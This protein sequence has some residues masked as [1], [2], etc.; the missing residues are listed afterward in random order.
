[1]SSA[2]VVGRTITAAPGG[3]I[4]VIVTRDFSQVQPVTVPVR[5][6]PGERTPPPVYVDLQSADLQSFGGA[7]QDTDA[8]TVTLRGVAEGTYHV[9][10]NPTQGY[11]ASAISGS[12]NLLTTPLRV[13]S[14]GRAGPI[15]VTLRDDFAS[16]SPRVRGAPAS[17]QV[18]PMLA[19][20]I[21]LDTPEVRVMPLAVYTTMPQA[22]S[23]QVPPGRYLVIGMMP[24]QFRTVQYRDPDVLRDLM[25]KGVTVTLGPGEKKE[26]EVSPL[27]EEDQ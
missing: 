21:P 1:V 24:A 16:L 8:D 5:G 13:S 15:Y 11:V 3:E 9:H 18:E 20:A 10:I 27:P 23:I 17:T 22:P 6:G 25:S 7:E 12:T 19:M 2:P 14:D 26:V 4:Q